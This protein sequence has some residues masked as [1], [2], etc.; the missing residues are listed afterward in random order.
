M[1]ATLGPYSSRS[2]LSVHDSSRPSSLTL[3]TAQTRPLSVASAAFFASSA[4]TSSYALAADRRRRTAILLELDVDDATRTSLQRAEQIL[5]ASEDA[6]AQETRRSVPFRHR[7]SVH[8]DRPSSLASSAANAAAESTDASECLTDSQAAARP[9]AADSPSPPLRRFSPKRLLLAKPR[10]PARERESALRQRRISPP[11]ALVPSPPREI[12]VAARRPVSA[13]NLLTEQTT[14]PAAATISGAAQKRRQVPARAG[15]LPLRNSRLVPLEDE[16]GS[17]FSGSSTDSLVRVDGARGNPAGERVRTKRQVSRDRGGRSVGFSTAN[18]L[19]TLRDKLGRGSTAV[20]AEP[21]KALKKKTSLASLFGFGGTAR[22]DESEASAAGAGAEVVVSSSSRQTFSS[23]GTSSH[24]PSTSISSYAPSSTHTATSGSVAPS[25]TSSRLGFLRSFRKRDSNSSARSGQAGKASRQISTAAIS[26]PIPLSPRQSGSRAAGGRAQIDDPAP[27]TTISAA[28]AAADPSPAR[29]KSWLATLGRSGAGQNVAAKRALFER[30]NNATIQPTERASGRDARLSPPL[31]G[32]SAQPGLEVNP[33][34]RSG[35]TTLIQDQ[36]AAPVRSRAAA[37]EAL[38]IQSSAPRVRPR[39]SAKASAQHR[40]LDSLDSGA[41]STPPA[42]DLWKGVPFLERSDLGW[43]AG[44]SPASTLDTDSSGSPP[45]P[46]KDARGLPVALKPVVYNGVGSPRKQAMGPEHAICID[47]HRQPAAPI[48]RVRGATTDLAELL[49]GLEDTIDV[50]T[51]AYDQVDAR[52]QASPSGPPVPIHDRAPA[53]P[54]VPA[55]LQQLIG[56]VDERLSVQLDDLAARGFGDEYDSCST[57]STSSSDSDSSEEILYRAELVPCGTGGGLLAPPFEY[58][59]RLANDKADSTG[60]FD[61]TKSSFEGHCTTAAAALRSMLSGQTVEAPSPPDSATLRMFEPKASATLRPSRMWE[62]AEEHEGA[63]PAA[64]PERPPVLDRPS[65]GEKMFDR[66]APEVPLSALV[67][68]PSPSSASQYGYGAGRGEHGSLVSSTEQ[69]TGVSIFSSPSPLPIVA[70]RMRQSLARYSQDSFPQRHQSHSARPDSIDSFSSS[71][72]AHSLSQ[73]PTAHS[74]ALSTLSTSLSVGSNRSSPCPAPRRRHVK[75]LTG[76][77][78]PLRPSFKFPLPSIR[79]EEGLGHGVAPAS[80]PFHE[81]PV[82]G[83]PGSEPV[84]QMELGSPFEGASE[85]YFSHVP[86]NI[87]LPNPADSPQ[88]LPSGPFDQ[89]VARR[90]PTPAG[91]DASSQRIVELDTTMADVELVAHASPEASRRYF[92]FTFQAETE[93]RRSLSLW[94][95]SDFSREVITFFV[96]PRTYFTIL[97]FL[98]DSQNRFP[99]PILPSRLGAPDHGAFDDP[100]MPPSPLSSVSS[101]SDESFDEAPVEAPPS[102]VR[103]LLPASWTD[104]SPRASVPLRPALAPKAVNRT[105][106][107]IA[108]SA[109]EQAKALSPFTARPPRLQVRPTCDTDFFKKKV[110]QRRQGQLDAAMRRLEGVGAPDEQKSGG[111][112]DDTGVLEAKGEATVDLT[113][114]KT[115]RHS[116]QRPRISRARPALTMMR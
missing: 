70:R 1:A 3:T 85:D 42:A 6:R 57:D 99:S 74:L 10:P 55:D 16:L 73:D 38:M 58:P 11:M 28:A 87:G 12:P 112:T 106:S 71:G 77:P 20:Q 48:H 96:L 25:R 108:F 23:S 56:V 89:A 100:S 60:G 109:V 95:D 18:G 54:D 83:V 8:L 46:E 103:P 44:M 90:Q 67:T 5:R 114:S 43:A 84:R 31:A 94:P 75:M 63:L 34:S 52:F 91:S 32:R 62:L 24:R 111:E 98:F 15:T 33:G 21:A 29:K 66:F 27:T 93:L 76:R 88:T 65:A 19:R 81:P 80:T 68:A 40:R 30:S 41:P 36:Y 49:V 107:A 102:R 22:G 39:A 86:S 50:D 78:P 79:D 64:S 113:F 51:T 7:G 59:S 101:D 4:S 17:K 92:A 53:A 2:R 37:I 110:T 14:Q 35:D 72:H 82:S 97:E 116:S 69:T 115:P 47:E 9:G 105:V 13:S 26:A 61:V 104:P 45:R